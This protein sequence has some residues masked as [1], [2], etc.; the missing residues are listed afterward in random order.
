MASCSVETRQNYQ[1]SVHHTLA[2][3]NGCPVFA[4]LLKGCCCCKARE[5]THGVGAESEVP[6]NLSGVLGSSEEDGVA[7]LWC[8]ERE[9]VERQAL[10]SCSL[11]PLLCRLCEPECGNRELLLQVDEPDI[12]RDGADDDDGVLAGVGFTVSDLARD[13]R[14]ADGWTVGLAHKKA[15]EDDPVELAVCSAGEEAV[16]L[17]HHIA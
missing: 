3:C 5:Q 9:L 4:A 13:A 16:E 8:T 11:D 14:Y 12:V 7:S 6:V 17:V 15:L 10:S 2:Y 1:Q